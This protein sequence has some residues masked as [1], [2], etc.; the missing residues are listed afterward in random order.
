MSLTAQDVFVTLLAIGA[1]WVIV[2]RVF[3]VFRPSA[4]PHCSNCASGAAACA[5]VDTEPPDDK[6][7]PL[8]LHR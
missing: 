4:R 2:R 8:V 6:P 7:V 1:A 3:G 5:R